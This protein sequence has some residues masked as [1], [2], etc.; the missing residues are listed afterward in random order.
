MGI[1]FRIAVSMVGTMGGDPEKRRRLTGHAPKNHERAFD[2]T[3][4]GEGPVSEEPVEADG[5]AEPSRISHCE[6]TDDGVCGESMDARQNDCNQSPNGWCE[7]GCKRVDP[8][9]IRRRQRLTI[10]VGSGGGSQK[11]SHFRISKDSKNVP[12]SV[13]LALNCRSPP[14]VTQNI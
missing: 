13:H 7:Y 12:N 2:R 11:T 10:G 5:H 8:L 9:V 3:V 4:S 14:T 6:E 1:A